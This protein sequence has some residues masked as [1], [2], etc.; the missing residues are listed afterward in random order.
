MAR[1]DRR[2]RQA[3]QAVGS[4]RIGAHRL[5]LKR[6]C[7]CGGRAR[8]AEACSDPGPLVPR[9][10]QSQDRP[11]ETA[12]GFA[13]PAAKPQRFQIWEELHDYQPQV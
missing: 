2:Y 9:R 7:F 10:V 8:P 4:S 1:N 6:D 3:V 5:E 13:I 11:I 12:P